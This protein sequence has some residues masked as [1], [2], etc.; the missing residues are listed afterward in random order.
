[1]KTSQIFLLIFIA[2]GFYFAQHGLFF[3]HTPIRSAEIG[4][5]TAGFGLA[6]VSIGLLVVA[7]E[8]YT[9]TAK[10]LSVLLILAGALLM[11]QSLSFF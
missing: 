2:L 3:H 11:L 5:M 10:I 1:M 7:M 8:I 6:F 4:E 9:A